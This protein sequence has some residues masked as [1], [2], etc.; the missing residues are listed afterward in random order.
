MGW[1][2]GCLMRVRRPSS[3]EARAV[4][5]CAVGLHVDATPLVAKGKLDSEA[6]T[7]RN[8]TFWTC[9]CQETL[10]AQYIGRKPMMMEYSVPLPT[11]DAATDDMLWI[12]PPGPLASLP[13]QKSYL[14]TGFVHT[15]ILIQA[16][17]E[18]AQSL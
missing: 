18:I 13:P 10:W 4:L 14:S 12:W 8:V 7:Q 16:C 6:A 2:T 15:T 11:A 17:T 3:P 5:T 9:Y 1:Q